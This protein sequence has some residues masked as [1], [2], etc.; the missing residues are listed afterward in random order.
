[1]LRLLRITLFASFAILYLAVPVFASAP[2]DQLNIATLT[3]TAGYTAGLPIAALPSANGSEVFFLRSGPADSLKS[4]YVLKTATGVSEKLVGPANL[5]LPNNGPTS[6]EISRD[7]TEILTCVMGKVFLIH[8]AGGQLLRFNGDGYSD[9]TLSPD[10]KSIAVVHDRD[11]SIIDVATGIAKPLTFGAN[12]WLTHGLPDT[13]DQRDFGLVRG[14]W[15]SPDSR[16]IAYVEADYR[17]IGIVHI[18]DFQHPEKDPASLRFPIA[19]AANAVVKLGMIDLTTGATAW[20]NY[21]NTVFP[22]IAGVT[23]SAPKAPLSV[24][25]LARDQKAEQLLAVAPKSGLTRTVLKET[26]P[27]WVSA[28][29][30]FSRLGLDRSPYWLPD[31]TAFLWL[32]EADGDWQIQ[33]RLRSGAL[34]RTLTPIGLHVRAI[35]DFNEQTNGVVFDADP[36]PRQCQL[37]RTDIK[38]GSCLPMT[39]TIGLHSA[40][41]SEDHSVYVDTFSLED[42]E[43]GADVFSSVTGF[44]LARLPSTAQIPAT[45]PNIKFLRVGPKHSLDAAVIFPSTFKKWQHYPVLLRV[46]DSVGESS[47]STGVRCYL[48]SQYYADQGYLVV[49]ID[50]TGTPNRGKANEQAVKYDLA[51]SPL[52]DQVEGLV[53]VGK[54]IPE[55]DLKHVCVLGEGS[56]ASLALMAILRRPDVFTCGIVSSPV[57]DWTQEDTAFTERYLD[58][59]KLDPVG[60]HVS[61]P[62]TYI[63]HLQRP[64]LVFAVAGSYLNFVQSLSFVETCD[65]LGKSCEFVPM[66]G[67]NNEQEVIAYHAKVVQFLKDHLGL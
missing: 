19:G 49:F 42:D 27:A 23:W 6:F 21:D 20:A 48:D 5:G 63:D 14:Y 40:V 66:T 25:V 7:G 30:D 65:E 39:H 2:S 8:V 16:Y 50:G 12:S 45:L 10:G 1:M 31:G 34:L 62:L 38:G 47:V 56:G 29:P 33:L 37:Y 35:D 59:P 60:Y 32:T 11:L 3:S 67:K 55:A 17:P 52:R 54:A 58:Q 53:D 41:F 28:A 4:L 61:S 57:T 64:L 43:A 9:A 51:T 18:V 46:N 24:I 36:D 15:W 44:R 13:L 26:D 22:Y